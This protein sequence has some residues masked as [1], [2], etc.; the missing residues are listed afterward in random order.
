ATVGL[1][2]KAA[3]DKGPKVKVK[4]SNMR[5]WLSTRTYGETVAYAKVLID[6]ATDR[7]LGAHMAG[8]GAEELIHLFSFAMVHGIT[9]RQIREHVFAL[10]TFSADIKSV[11]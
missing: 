11:V 3:R 1:T 9:A 5:E 6:E 2:E 7:I 8:H 10:P 4:V